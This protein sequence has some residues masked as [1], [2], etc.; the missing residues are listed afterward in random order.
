MTMKAKMKRT[1]T[2]RDDR[3]R[4]RAAARII[5][6]RI[7][8]GLPAGRDPA[9][10]FAQ[11]TFSPPLPCGVRR[12]GDDQPN[13]PGREVRP[14]N[15]TGDRQ[16]MNTYEEKQEAKRERLLERA[17]RAEA[18]SESRFKTAQQMGSVIPFGQPIL[19]GHHSETRDRNYRKRIASNYDKSAEASRKAKRLRSRAASVGKGGISS[20]DPEAVA[21]LKEK[22]AH[23]EKRQD[24]MRRFNVAMRKRKK[25]GGIALQAI[26][27]EFNLAA[28]M[29]ADLLK[30]DCAGRI[31]FA[32]YQLQNNNAQ[33]RRLKRRIEALEAQAGDETSETKI[34]PVTIVENVGE[35][36]LQLFFPGKPSAEFRRELKRSGFRWARSV[37]AWQRHRS[38]GATYWGRTLAE[39]FAKDE[40]AA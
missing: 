15:P 30:P 40:A 33:I 35:N 39:Q 23:R 19:V 21:K 32:G 34:G 3:R 7:G 36:R 13:G 8:E 16:S 22:L 5:C 14:T 2:A 9:G 6:R 24:F 37:G 10:S 28:G 12:A 17:D 27:A 29:V 38:H 26:A 11:I 1:R 20:D 4:D 18:E 31:G 25:D